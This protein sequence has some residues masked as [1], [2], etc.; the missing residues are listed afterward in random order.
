MREGEEDEESGDGEDELGHF[1]D[2]L[3]GRRGWLEVVIYGCEAENI[4]GG[5]IFGQFGQRD[6][7]FDL[8]VRVKCGQRA[9]G[10]TAHVI[11]FGGRESVPLFWGF[12]VAFWV[13]TWT[14]LLLRCVD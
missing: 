5:S 6:S 1:D 10:F 7:G 11:G 2:R 3:I 8:C 4:G 9:R 14:V 13:H 12:C